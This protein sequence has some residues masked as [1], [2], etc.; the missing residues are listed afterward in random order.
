ME[1]ELYNLKPD[2]ENKYSELFALYESKISNYPY[3]NLNLILS[4]NI[5]NDSNYPC[6]IVMNSKK[7]ARD[8]PKIFS[9]ILFGIN[10]NRKS[11]FQIN[12][13]KYPWIYIGFMNNPVIRLIDSLYNSGKKEFSS[14]YTFKKISTAFCTATTIKPANLEFQQYQNCA[15]ISR[16]AQCKA[17]ISLNYL[18][19]Y[20]G[21]AIFE[22]IYSGFLQTYYD[23]QITTN[24]I[25]SY[26]E[27]EMS[28][29][30]SWFFNGL[31]GDADPFR[32]SITNVTRQPESLTLTIENKGKFPIPFEIG[33][34]K[35]DSILKIQKI[36]GF[37][38]KKTITIN[39]SNA[40]KIKI[41]PNNLYYKT[42]GII[43]E[44]YVKK[45]YV[46]TNA[47]SFYKKN[48]PTNIVF[49]F[50]GY[51]KSDGL[52]AGGLLF[53]VKKIHNKYSLLALYGFRTK[54]PV[55]A[56]D[57]R[58]RFYGLNG[59]RIIETGI[60]GRSFHT[61]KKD[62]FKLRYKRL[63]VFV[64][65]I[66]RNQEII[67]SK[68]SYKSSI[69]EDESYNGTGV[70][71]YYRY[72]SNVAFKYWGGNTIIPFEYKISL[73]HQYYKYFKTNQYVQ[74]SGEMKAAYMYKK[75][76]FFRI[77]LYAATYLYNT[78]KNTTGTYPGTLSLIGFGRNDYGY[79][80][81]FIDRRA[82]TGFWS[83]QLMMNTGGFKTAI[84]N[85]QGLGQSNKYVMSANL[86]LDLPVKI[87]IKPYVDFGFYGYLPTISEGYSNKFIYSGGIMF[88]LIKEYFDIYLPLI[89]S[90]DI[91]DIYKEDP[92]IL[93]RF[94]FRAKMDFRFNLKL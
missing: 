24:S 37:T 6:N 58:Y 87:F 63:S 47:F 18:N 46:N 7:M 12:P 83:R 35:A 5:V 80:Q 36:E 57:Y 43:T 31:L 86:I 75:D 93:N 88:E 51:N 92:G 27:K 84:G 69:I 15:K 91:N 53:D 72:L 14:D 71:K 73:E 2:I 67:K 4:N 79:E 22:K 49:P 55:G 40:E 68:I 10:K 25:R 38:G 9:G 39:P 26:F 32:Y 81:Y 82:Q 41:D 77:R 94:S 52:L 54:S 66:N 21:N 70:D 76:R 56:G 85:A 19:N 23:K 30:L 65:I 74:I 59:K 16:F 33:T 64:N 89:N 34:I 90:K 44:T 60:Q 8:Y 48:R 61:L 50:I 45:R 11:L 1:N 13:Y 20:L 29:D 62:D 28:K 17:N 3:S 42:G 78:N